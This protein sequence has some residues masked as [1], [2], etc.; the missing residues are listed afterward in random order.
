MLSINV[1]EIHH[2]KLKRGIYEDDVKT[3]IKLI[4]D[5]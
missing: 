1:C 3:D 2:V 5:S 4:Y